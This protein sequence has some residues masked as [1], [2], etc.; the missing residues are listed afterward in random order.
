MRRHFTVTTFVSTNRYTLLHWHQKNQMWL[1]PGGHIEPNEDP[2]Q[3]ALREALEETGVHIV[4]LP[5]RAPFQYRQPLQLPAPA[6]IMLEDI[7]ATS[8][9]PAHQHLDLI[10]FSRPQ[11]LDPP[12]PLGG[13]WRWVTAD[14]L[15]NNYALAPS[16]GSPPV[17][18]PEDV[19]ML[20][21]AAIQH[22]AQEHA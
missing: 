10:Y 13:T 8:S 19:R 5:T 21:L 22:C 4:I 15:G 20:G 9:E 14:E 6:T 16:K 12:A 2:C 7:P 18:V 1:P 17:S 3:A 11:D